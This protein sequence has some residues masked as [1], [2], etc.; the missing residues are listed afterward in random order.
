MNR[1][2]EAR[3][4]SVPFRTGQAAAETGKGNTAEAVKMP[5]SWQLGRQRTSAGL[6]Q[7]LCEALSLAVPIGSV[8]LLGWKHNDE[9]LMDRLTERSSF[10]SDQPALTIAET[11]KERKRK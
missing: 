10:L 5:E 3:Y 11:R 2:I 4:A 1:L 7:G 8:P 6:S 9:T